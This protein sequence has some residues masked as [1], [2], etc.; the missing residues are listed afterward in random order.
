MVNAKQGLL[1]TRDLKSVFKTWLRGNAWLALTTNS[2]DVNS[3]SAEVKF[4][5]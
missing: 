1:L 2:A 5:G 4:H 3:A